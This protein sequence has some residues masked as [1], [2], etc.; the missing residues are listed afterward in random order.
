MGGKGRCC[1]CCGDLIVPTDW[2][3]VASCCAQCQRT[4]TDEWTN[5]C[6]DAIRTDTRSASVDLKMYTR[7]LAVID[8]EIQCVEDPP[9]SGIIVCSV[10]GIPLDGC[11]ADSLCGTTHYAQTT[12]QSLKLVARWKRTKTASTLS[13]IETLCGV[14]ESPT[15]KWLLISRVCVTIEWGYKWFQDDDQLITNDSA[16]CKA[17]ARDVVVA[18]PSCATA[19]S[20]MSIQNVTN[21]CF[22]RSKYFTSAPSG[23]VTLNPGDIADCDYNIE[24]VC[25]PDTFPVTSVDTDEITLASAGSSDPIAWTAPACVTATTTSGCRYVYKP[26]AGNCNNAVIVEDSSHTETR[27]SVSINGSLLGPL[28]GVYP[29]A[30]QSACQGADLCTNWKEVTRMECANLTSSQ[31][32]SGHTNRS[33]TIS[34]PAWTVDLASCESDSAVSWDEY[35]RYINYDPINHQGL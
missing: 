14:E 3:L 17:T 27:T 18:A 8:D 19:A 29:M 24:T 25:N 22:T 26:N 1:C 31:T 2:D 21:V 4:L 16:C 7:E 32:G 28:S 10:G 9:M 5:I 23:T 35:L 13:R 30:F 20:E 11:P 12:S 6:S 33:I 15:C 34:L